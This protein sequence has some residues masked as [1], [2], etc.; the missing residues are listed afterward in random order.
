M[1]SLMRGRWSEERGAE[2]VEFAI[3]L[4]LLLLILVGIIDFG[5]LF[6]RYQ[7]LTNAARE[8]ARVSVLPGYQVAD[9]QARVTQF[10]VA[11][12][13]TETPTTTVGAA[14]SVPVGGGQCIRVRPVTVEYPYSYSAVG[15]LASV[16]GSGFSRTGLQAT[17]TMRSELAAGACGGA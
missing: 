14:A 8:G 10:L 3:V 13:L 16:F 1:A 6:Q 5:L 12:G 7:V 15:A 11:S 17:A 9:V 4:P 2:I